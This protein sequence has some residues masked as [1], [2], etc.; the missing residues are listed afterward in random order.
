MPSFP[1]PF[2]RAHSEILPSIHNNTIH[3]TREQIVS[4]P[5]I[6]HLNSVCLRDHALNA[7]AFCRRTSH[8]STH[9]LQSPSLSASGREGLK[10][11]T[12]VSASKTTHLSWL[13][14][15]LLPKQM[16]IYSDSCED[17]CFFG[18]L[19]AGPASF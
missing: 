14:Q 17:V 5:Q 3:V 12:L 13:V 7:G 15:L 10:L 8:P 1:W 2:L 4:L 6:P 9:T 18:I 11:G 16:A 19:E